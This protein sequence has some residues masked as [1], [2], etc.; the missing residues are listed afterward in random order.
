MKYIVRTFLIYVLFLNFVLPQKDIKEG[1]YKVS[2]LKIEGLKTLN[3]GT[4]ANITGLYIGKEITIPGSDISNAIQKLWKQEVFKFVQ[5][6]VEKIIQDRIYLKVLLEEYPRISKYTFTGVTKNQAD[7]IRK[8]IDFARGNIYN[9]TKQRNAERIIKNYF[10]EKGFYNTTVRFEEKTDTFLIN[11][12]AVKIIID[13]GSK[14]K[15]HNII[16][17]GNSKIS[18]KTLKRKLKKTKEKKFWRIWKR[19]KLVPADFAKDKEALI[20]FYRTKGFRDAKLI[21]DSVAIVNE[22]ELDLYIKLYEGNV[23]YIRNI[24][25]VGNNKYDD[26]L[27]GKILG[28]KKGDVYN[29]SLLER[30]L[31]MDPTG[32]D[33]SSLYMDDGHLFFRAE[34]VE[35]SVE[36]DSVDL[37]IRIFEGPQAYI[38]KIIV[39]GNTKTSD[40]VIIRELRTLPGNKF[41]RSDVIRSQRE[42]ANLNYFDPQQ[43]GI[44]PVPHQEDGTVDITYDLTEKPSD[45]IF[46]QGG[47]GGNIR[48]QYGNVISSGL[49]LTLGLTLNNFSTRKLLHPKEWNPIPVGDGQKMSL[50]IQ[51]N[52]TGFQNYGISFTEPWFGGKKPISLGF[53]VNYSIQKSL[54]TDY[55]ISIFNS[56]IDLGRRLKFPDDF[57]RSYTSLNYRYYT[58]RNAYGVFAGFSDGFINILSLKQVFDRTS[59]DAPIYPTSGSSVSLGIEVTPPYSLFIKKD[60]ANLPPSEK[61]NLLEFH[62]WTFEAK[63]YLKIIGKLVVAPRMQF[64]F[65]GAYNKKL[66]GVSPF[67][68]FYIGG[69]GLQ[70]YNLDG[71]TVIPLRG[72]SGPQIGSVLGNTIYDRFIFDVRQALSTSQMATFWVHGFFEAGN[73]WAS[74]DNFNPFELKRSVG[75]GVRVFMPMFGLLG[76]DYGYGIDDVY[77]PSGSKLNGGQFHFMIG[78]EF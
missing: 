5:I 78:R 45:Q 35:V 21:K 44:N 36:G 38:N 12:V 41:S 13:K 28:L 77:T 37:E 42:L 40:K 61:Y 14:T 31:Y 71:R 48:D 73:A 25:W 69:D 54:T 4:V 53:R 49:L 74:T 47:W 52:G 32:G 62:R 43:M 63:Y 75:G 56:S 57:F 68:R 8:H 10:Q 70:G 55:F 64:G 7:E 72:Y 24:E 22:K 19:S 60:Y 6:E 11:G 76:V 50:S 27:L 16:I 3:A 17:E 2:G 23:Y 15:I 33:I 67:Q 66:L 20:S 29:T 46:L 34:P 39:K 9:P 30:K 51:V 26:V 58:V 65:L 59:I 18:D 1:T